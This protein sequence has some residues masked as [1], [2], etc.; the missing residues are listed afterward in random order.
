MKNLTKAMALVVTAGMAYAGAAY[1]A[2]GDAQ[3]GQSIAANCAACHGRDGNQTT[4]QTI[5]KLAQQ[6]EA[7]LVK[8][9]HDFKSGARK[10][11]IMSSMAS[12]LSDQGVKDVA[13]YFSSQKM[14]SDKVSDKSLADEGK[15]IFTGGIAKDSVPACS[16]C[17]GTHAEGMPPTF[18]RLAGQHAQYVVAQLKTFKSG[19]RANDP[20]AVMRNIASKLSDHQ[21][22]AVAEYVTGL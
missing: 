13:A 22:E 5:P 10:N 3:K 11:S 4:A 17:H 2:G 8:Q 20:N 14:G 19:D 1:G 9:L 12:T 15:Q 16:S 6:I 18:P 21:M 7:Y